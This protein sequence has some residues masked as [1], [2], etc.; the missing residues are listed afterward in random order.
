MH[1]AITT[2]FLQG[3]GDNSLKKG[4]VLKNLP[5]LQNFSENVLDIA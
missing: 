3:P 1:K 5:K 2:S 4:N